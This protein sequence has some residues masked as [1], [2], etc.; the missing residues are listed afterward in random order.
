MR[1]FKEERVISTVP[2]TPSKGFS[3]RRQLRAPLEI[4]HQGHTPPPKFQT[5]LKFAEVAAP[6]AGGWV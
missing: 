2:L 5:L 1:A 3:S 4:K 6:G